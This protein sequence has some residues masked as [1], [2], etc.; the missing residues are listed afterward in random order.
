[1]K[2]T[3]GQERAI[4]ALKEAA[5]RYGYDKKIQTPHGV[6]VRTLHALVKTVLFTANAK[7]TCSRIKIIRG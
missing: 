1:M 7:V 3:I 2:L 5:D 6:Q 4:K